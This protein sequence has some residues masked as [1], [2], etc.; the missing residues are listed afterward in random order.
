MSQP[1][2]GQQ[3]SPF[4]P[5]TG[6]SQGP[7]SGVDGGASPNGGFGGGSYGPA[8]YGPP[9]G[10]P[11]G[12]PAPGYG[13]P[14]Q[15]GAYGQQNPYAAPN[16]YGQG[17]YAPN[18]FDMARETQLREMQQNGLMWLLVGAVGF[19][20]G[21]GWVTGPLSWYFG[22]KLRKD[23]KQMGVEPTGE[24]TGAWVVGI[25]TT[26]ISWL[27]IL[28]AIFFLVMFFGAFFAAASTAAAAGAVTP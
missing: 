2:Y 22:G 27:A 10:S 13:P 15:Q 12:A 17:A 24:A 9:Q 18:G 25:V 20:F 6:Y 5:P 28:A 21:F 8:Q 14:P 4:A 23:Y 7:S 19:F 1:P 11:Q 26:A 3:Q 16:A